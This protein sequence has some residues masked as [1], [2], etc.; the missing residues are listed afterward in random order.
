[1]SPA[2][3]DEAALCDADLAVLAADPA[4]YAAYAAGVRAEYAHIDEAGWRTGRAAVLRA[5]L[6]RPVLFHTAAMAGRDAAAHAD[7]AAELA[8]LT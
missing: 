5:F 3:P 1:M 6:E 2:A 7:L 4:T 8:T